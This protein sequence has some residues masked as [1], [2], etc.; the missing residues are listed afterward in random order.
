MTILLL[1]LCPHIYAQSN[2]V[3]HIDYAYEHYF[4]T[5]RSNVS[6]IF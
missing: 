1:V 3:T 6:Y 4:A 2:Y 5:L